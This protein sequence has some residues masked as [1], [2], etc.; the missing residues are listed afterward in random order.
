V[1]LFGEKEDKHAI[2]LQYFDIQY[3]FEATKHAS[4]RSKVD[5]SLSLKQ[6]EQF[7]KKTY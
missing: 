4:G 3:N 6:T 5:D 2:L 7:T 1:L